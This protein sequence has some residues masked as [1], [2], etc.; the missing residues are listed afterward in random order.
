MRSGLMIRLEWLLSRAAEKC[1]K[2]PLVAALTPKMSDAAIRAAFRICITICCVSVRSLTYC[3][4][5]FQGARGV[6]LGMSRIH[7]EGPDSDP[8]DRSVA[9]NVLLRQQ[10]DLS[11]WV[12]DEA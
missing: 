9:A 1:S 6:P 10:P 11:Q 3:R 2:R 4:C 12:K 8:S 5:G 7:P